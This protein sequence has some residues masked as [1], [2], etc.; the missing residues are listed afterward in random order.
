MIGFVWSEI[1]TQPGEAFNWLF[2][3]IDRL[4]L[5]L[6]KPLGGC[7]KCVTGQI[8]LWTFIYHYHTDYSLFWHIYFVSLSILITWITQKLTE[9][10]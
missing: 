7:A 9:R 1:L 4:P 5:W 8:A 2:K 6:S 3:Y 10:F